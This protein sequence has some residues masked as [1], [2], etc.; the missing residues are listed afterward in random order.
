MV[1]RD[2]W[3][4]LR[5]VEYWRRETKGKDGYR[6]DVADDFKRRKREIAEQRE[7]N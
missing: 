4:R 1:F 7:R 2:D 5:V 6:W 3:E